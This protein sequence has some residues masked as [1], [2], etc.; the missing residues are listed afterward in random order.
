MVMIAGG[1][2]VQAAEL[3]VVGG[4]LVVMSLTQVRAPARRPALAGMKQEHTPTSSWHACCC[5]A[6]ALCAPQCC[7]FCS[8]TAAQKR[9]NPENETG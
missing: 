7:F 6:I 4:Y 1:V 8:R 3:K 5:V 2:Q 9:K